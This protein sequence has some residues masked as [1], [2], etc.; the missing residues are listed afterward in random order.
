M[1]NVLL[2]SDTLGSWRQ[3]TRYL[4]ADGVYSLGS[5]FSMTL[6]FTKYLQFRSNTQANRNQSIV[7]VDAQE[8]KNNTFSWSQIW[9]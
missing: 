6:P 7:Y 3:E 1:S 5:S 9:R 2:L 8:V 4:N